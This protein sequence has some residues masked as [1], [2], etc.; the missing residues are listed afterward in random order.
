MTFIHSYPGFVTTDILK[1]SPDFPGWLKWIIETLSTN[2]A[3]QVTPEEAALCII[4]GAVKVWHE[5]NEKDLGGSDQPVRGWFCMSEKG[6]VY[7]KPEAS[8]NVRRRVREHTWNLVDQ[9]MDGGVKS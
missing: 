5:Q 4:G 9:A 1:K 3:K 6:E 8:E 7:D 2:V